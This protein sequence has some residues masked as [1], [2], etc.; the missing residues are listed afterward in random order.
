MDNSKIGVIKTNKINSNDGNKITLFEYLAYIFCKCLIFKEDK[1]NM[2]ERYV[3][4]REVNKL[5][6]LYF[7]IPN[8][9]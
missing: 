5:L 7:I 3:K 4:I 8:I 2:D 9:F 6:D 1:S